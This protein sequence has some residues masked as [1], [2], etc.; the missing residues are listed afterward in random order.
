METCPE[1]HGIDNVDNDDSAEP[2]RTARRLAWTEK[3]DIRLRLV[4]LLQD[5]EV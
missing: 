5:Q 3:E 2:E 4:E 1:E